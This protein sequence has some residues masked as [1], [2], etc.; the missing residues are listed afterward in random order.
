MLT[1]NRGSHQL[2][3]MENVLNSEVLCDCD[4]MFKLAPNTFIILLK[5]MRKLLRC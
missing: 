5:A 4:E 1:Q 2:K 3:S